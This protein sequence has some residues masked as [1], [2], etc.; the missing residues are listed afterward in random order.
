MECVHYRRKGDVIMRRKAI[1]PPKHAKRGFFSFNE[2]EFAQR[3][4]VTAIL[5]NLTYTRS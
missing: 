5:S 3:K 4:I 1:N 2:V